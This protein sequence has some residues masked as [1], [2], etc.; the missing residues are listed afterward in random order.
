M[1][2]AVNVEFKG[3]AGMNRALAEIAGRLGNGGA[4][5]V[6]FLEK[7]TYPVNEKGKSLS[8]AQVAFWNEWGTV[9]SPPRPF[10][11]G[12]I[13]KRSPRWGE[14]LAA[15]AKATHYD[16]QATLAA[17]GETIKGQ[18]QRSINE[19]MT[20]GNAPS[21][22]R[23]KGFDKPLIDKATMLRAVDYEVTT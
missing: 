10:F 11:R 2:A 8:V 19:F 7:A 5:N 16:T 15:A 17:A 21:T 13:A 23:K 1:M 14:L 18:L 6:G 22:I 3:G 12:M 9:R 20:P 4:V